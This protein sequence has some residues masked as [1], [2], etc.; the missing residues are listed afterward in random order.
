MYIIMNL[1]F[2]VVVSIVLGMFLGAR[3]LY[4]IMD[5]RDLTVDDITNLLYE[6]EEKESN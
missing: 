3:I 1:I 2:M 4:K 5:D 6:S